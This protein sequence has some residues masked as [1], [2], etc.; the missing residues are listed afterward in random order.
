MKIYRASS[1]GPMPQQLG[2]DQDS[3]VTYELISDGLIVCD[4]ATET[5][6]TVRHGDPHPP[7]QTQFE[8]PANV[9]GIIAA[10]DSE[11]KKAVL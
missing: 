4:L 11:L 8:L 5:K 10:T 3:R 9:K 7:S 2:I 1:L 6:F